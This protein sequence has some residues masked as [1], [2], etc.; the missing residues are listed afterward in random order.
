MAS[1]PSP[2]NKQSQYKYDVF[3]SFRG[4]DTR[5]NFVD[6]LHDALRR[7]GIMAFKDDHDRDLPR[8]KHIK[9]EILGAIEKSRYVLVIFS[10]NYASST[11]CLE[12]VA[13]ALECKDIDE[14]SVIPIFYKVN[15]SDIRKLRGN[16]GR[17]FAKIEE[18]YTRDKGDVKRWKDALRK[19][20]D[21]AGRE[22]K[23]GY[24]TKFIQQI[25]GEIENKLGPRLSSVVGN[26]VGMHSRVADVVEHLCLGE[27]DVRS[28]GIWGMGGIGK[29]TVAR[30]VYDRICGKFDDGCSFL[31]NVREVSEKNG[32]IYLQNEFLGD[33][34]HEDN[35]RIR[36]D[37]R[38]AN[39]IKE[40]LRHKK[41]LL[42]LDDV[43]EKEQLE[44][45]AGDLDW[46][47]R[48]SRIIIT[49][50]D[51][52][53]LL[54][55]GVNAIYKAEKLSIDE[56]LEL[57]C[58]KSFRSQDPSA[59]FE[60]LVEQ[61]IKYTDGLP[62]ALDV[63]GS[64]SANRSLMQWKSALARLKECPERKIIDLLRLSYDGLMQI[65]KEI[66]LDIACFFKGKEKTYVTEVLDNCGFYPDIGMEVLVDR[67][68]IEIRDNKL[69]M[70]DL[71]QE[72]AWEIVRQESPEEPGERSR[73]WLFKDVCHILSKN[74]GTGKVKGIVLQSGDWR[75]V[76]LNGESFTN[77]TNLRLLDIHAIR[78]SSGVKHLSNELRL[79]IWDNCNL[80][81]LPP[82]FI[83]KN[84]LELNMWD[85]LLSRLWR[86]E[87]VLEKL[88]VINLNGSKLFVETP[89]FINV[90]NLERLILKG[91]KALSQ[92]HPS[93]G[94][95]ER[96]SV[97]DLGD[98]ENLTR[99]PDSV[100]NLKSLKVLNLSG[101]SNLEELPESMGGLE[102]L[103]ELDISES[104]ITHLPSSLTFL[105]N[106]KN[107]WFH[108]SKGRRQDFWRT[109]TRMLRSTLNSR[110]RRLPSFSGLSSLTELDMS[111][112]SLLEGEIPSDIGCLPSLRF[113]YLA[114]NSFTTLPASIN[115]ISDLESLVLNHCKNLETLPR[116]PESIIFVEADKCL[117]LERMSNPFI[118]CTISDSRFCFVN[119]SRLLP[120]D[121][122]LTLQQKYSLSLLRYTIW[123]S[124]RQIPD[125]YVVFP[126]LEGEIPEWF[127]YQT[128]G[129]LLSIDMSPNW[130]NNKWKGFAICA[131]FE[132][133]NCNSC[134]DLENAPFIFC[135]FY[136]D[137]NRLVPTVEFPIRFVNSGC[138][139]LGYV[140]YWLWDT[141]WRGS[142]RIDVSL[143]I[144][145]P[146]LK[147]GKCGVHLVYRT[148]PSDFDYFLIRWSSSS[149]RDWDRIYHE[150][151]QP[152][153][154]NTILE[155]S[156]PPYSLEQISKMHEVGVRCGFRNYLR[157]PGGHTVAEFICAFG[158]VAER[159]LG[160]R[161]RRLRSLGFSK[162]LWRDRSKHG[163]RC[164]GDGQDLAD[165][166]AQGFT[167]LIQSHMTPP[168][169]SWPNPPQAKLFDLEIL[170]QQSFVMADFKLYYVLAA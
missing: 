149:P 66:F 95:L 145:N 102:C 73:I 8:G 94:M 96:L 46:F 108:V 170:P 122:D 112:C 45:L 58:L 28:I 24:E 86:G 83:P 32:L 71:L 56:A 48:G 167:G 155:R 78:L 131:S 153:E 161:R 90:P 147:V 33:I 150:F 44:K 154:G 165:R 6:H 132:R 103:E 144:T 117:R 22:L 169:F 69:W 163:R 20:A 115:H 57:F 89:N 160:R 41:V 4:E 121:L 151:G 87:K 52:H 164:S 120:Q 60:E 92:V 36:D 1:F 54:Q 3:L 106:L 23:D 63:L 9:P 138:L 68:L 50:R 128:V 118:I 77:M 157:Y 30:A 2:E 113:L 110:L 16:F 81:L 15:P 31:A 64:F 12:E 74:S 11:W 125:T 10:E 124:V 80:K 40:R 143:R 97:L 19:V 135:D 82:G 72:M 148:H 133:T 62:L 17:D 29:T 38:G 127:S 51:Q 39:M 55:Y 18:T 61:F 42:V 59:G 84:L 75:T 111:G 130:F 114:E 156:Y 37:H 137:G 47:G 7:R 116:L 67:S 25:I 79:L 168:S 159:N 35:L 146:V 129:P 109:L 107:L 76:C 123:C 34:L 85:C 70:H 141:N 101:C 49:T 162:C 119:C 158:H 166:L 88:K 91:C 98:C 14:G 100:G 134:Q 136:V 13:K 142:N 105:K 5:K 99:L 93:I 126:C 26:L 53:L 27:S 139:W 43:D 140:P 152:R 21:L 65:E 104:A